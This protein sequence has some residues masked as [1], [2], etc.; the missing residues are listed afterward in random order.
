M[1]TLLWKQLNLE[2]QW[3][4]CHEDLN[5]FFNQWFFGSGQP[6]LTVTDSMDAS[7]KKLYLTVQQTQSGEQQQH[8]FQLPVKSGHL[9]GGNTKPLQKIFYLQR[10][11]TFSFDVDKA[12][13]NVIFDANDVLLAKIKY[14]KPLDA[15]KYQTTH[16]KTPQRPDDSFR[17]DKV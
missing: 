6:E 14:D 7:G 2:W 5:W 16:Y 13:V 1:P 12:P 11:Q 8:I 10:N 3:K 4:K 9:S 15:Y 17:Q